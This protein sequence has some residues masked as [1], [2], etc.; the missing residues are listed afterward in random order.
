MKMKSVKMNMSYKMHCVLECINNKS[1]TWDSF[2]SF[3]EI[4]SPCVHYLGGVHSCAKPMVLWLTHLAHI[5][6]SAKPS[7]IHW[8]FS[9]SCKKIKKLRVIHCLAT[10]CPTFGACTPLTQVPHV[11]KYLPRVLRNTRHLCEWSTSS[12][13]GAVHH[14]EI[15]CCKNDFKKHIQ[16]QSLLNL[17]CYML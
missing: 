12:E 4:G 9:P 14:S 17:Q 11:P 15:K 10:Y 8:V 2:C 16:D 6:S 7:M 3:V 1:C 13:G 5:L